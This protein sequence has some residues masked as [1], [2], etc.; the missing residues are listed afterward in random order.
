MVDFL[1]WLRD[2]VL[3]TS[4]GLPPERFLITDTINGR[5]L[6]A[7]LVHELDVEWSWRERL[8]GATHA[9]G[10][11]TE[12]V[13]GDYPTVADVAARWRQ[14]EIEMRAWL[15]SLSDAELAADCD[16]EGKPGY[17]LWTFV[18][19]VVVHGVEQFTDAAT[20]LTR[21]GHSPGNLEFLDYWDARLERAADG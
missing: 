19:H 8:Q 17:P 12:L 4:E 20:L 1:Y 21:A 18:T 3:T 14:D 5:D 6:R 2:R 7:T 10:S 16:V 13:P 11:P 9:P 15:A